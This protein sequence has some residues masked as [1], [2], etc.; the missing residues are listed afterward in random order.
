MVRAVEDSQRLFREAFPDGWPPG[1]SPR[2]LFAATATVATEL[3]FDASAF[4][5]GLTNRGDASELLYQLN[6]GETVG[7]APDVIVA[8]IANAVA[9]AVRLGGRPLADAERWFDAFMTSPLVLHPIKPLATAAIDVAIRTGLSAYD[10]FYA[11]L[12]ATLEVP[13]VT[14][15]RKLA[16]AV[17][18]AV[19]VD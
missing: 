6:E 8:E 2:R 15:D 19:L 3:V 7:H 9:L 13:L 18:G 10:A 1:S 4:F 5:R 11:V 12:S 17:P 14:A 16:A